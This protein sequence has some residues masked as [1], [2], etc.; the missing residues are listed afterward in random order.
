VD[1]IVH[2]LRKYSNIISMCV[3]VAREEILLQQ[4]TKINIKKKL[5]EEKSIVSK[6]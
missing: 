5:M 3:S 2:S 4:G 6:S 1:F